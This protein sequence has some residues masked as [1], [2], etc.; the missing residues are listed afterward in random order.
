[1]FLLAGK[2]IESLEFNITRFQRGGFSLLSKGQENYTIKVIRFIRSI[3]SDLYLYLPLITIALISRET[4]SNTIKLLYSSPIKIS[5]I[6]IGKFTGMLGFLFSCFVLILFPVVALSFSLSNPDYGHIFTSLVTLFLVMSLFAAIGLFIAA[7]IT[8]VILAF[9]TKASRY[10]QNI[11]ALR[12]ITFY[13]DLENKSRK[14]FDGII[15]LRDI[16]YFLVL[17]GCFLSFSIIRLKSATISISLLGKAIR[18]FVVIIIGFAIALITSNPFVN[19]YADSTRDD[20]ETIVP[21]TQEMLAKLDK[22]P[23]EITVFVN[24]VNEQVDE[25]GYWQRDMKRNADRDWEKIIRFKPDTKVK[26]VYYYDLD[27]SNS[28]FKMHRKLTLKQIATRVADVNSFDIDDALSPE[29][30]NKIVDVK[31]QEYRIFYQLSYQGEKTILRPFDD[32]DPVNGRFPGDEHFIVAFNQLLGSKLPRVLCLT[33]EFERSTFTKQLR[34][35]QYFT[36]DIGFSKSL[37]NRGFDVDTLSLKTDDIPTDIAALVIADPRINFTSASL[38]KIKKYIASGGNLLINAEPDRKEVIQP[39]LDELGISIR[40]GILIQPSEKYS[41]DRIFNRLSDTAQRISTH[42]QRVIKD[43]VRVYGDTVFPVIMDG[44]GTLA[45]T[46]QNGFEYFPLMTTD[47]STTWNRLAP[48]LED[49]LQE[50]IPKRIDDENGSFVTALLV[51]RKINGKEQRIIVASD[52]DYL[53]RP[54]GHWRLNSLNFD[55]S[56]WFFNYFSYGQYP[57]VI[58]WPQ[59]IDNK[60]K[61]TLADVTTQRIIIYYMVPAMLVIIGSIVLIRRK[62]K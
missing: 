26:Y 10:W 49:S 44:A 46:Q 56:L 12:D 61:I 17:I 41:S 25:Y 6:V 33:D 30:I 23:L 4:S 34:D 54:L 19:V 29:E 3:V 35:Y 24:I 52:A 57:P 59:A 31:K 47:Q 40:P 39:L 15:N 55:F 18:Y 5:E 58:V 45:F 53:T 9:I 27:S 28:L 2:Y 8:F 43:R 60:F 38:A 36:T 51:K 1:M 21:A 62:R 32:P 16:S 22:G 14:L 48:I 42:F 11:D 50:Q 13:L 7:I 20:L 37:N